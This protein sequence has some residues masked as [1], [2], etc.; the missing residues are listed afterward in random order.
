MRNT[1]VC[2]SWVVYR[3]TPHGSQLGINVVCEQSEWE[4]MERVR[5]GQQQLVQS[6]ISNE[7]IAERLARG[8]SG[9]PKPRGKFPPQAK[10][11]S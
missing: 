10:S 2:T 3:T 6:G 9:D 11:A 5:P 7:G 1:P 8:T 4:A